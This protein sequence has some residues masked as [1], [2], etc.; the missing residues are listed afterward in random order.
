MDKLITLRHIYIYKCIYL[1]LY[2]YLYFLFIYIYIYIHSF[3]HSFIYLS[4]SLSL[5]S[6]SLS[7]YSFPL[8][9][10]LS[11]AFFAVPSQGLLLANTDEDTL[12]CF[13]CHMC[14]RSESHKDHHCN[15]VPLASTFFATRCQGLS[16]A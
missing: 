14:A 12:H 4:L 1:Y 11:Y 9:L 15:A 6:F 7:L 8:S 5:Y 10:Y 13:S 2:L 3:I 16:Y